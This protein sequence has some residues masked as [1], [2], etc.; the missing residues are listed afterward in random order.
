MR[1]QRQRIEAASIAP[2]TSAGAC[3]LFRR[4]KVWSRFCNRQG[5]LRTRHTEP[6]VF[7]SKRR[8]CSTCRRDGDNA[9]RSRNVTWR[10][11]A[12]IATSAPP[13]VSFLISATTSHC[14]GIQHD[15]RAHSFRHFHSNGIAFHADDERSADQF[16]PGGGAQADGSLRKNR[17][18]IA[19]ANIRRFCAAESSRS[20]VSEQAPLV[21]LSVRLESWPG[22]PAHLEQA[23]IRPARR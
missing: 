18:C 6:E 11:S 3:V 16:R 4:G 9:E 15:V 12:S 13:P 1:D 20:D 2:S 22:S 19:D 7:P 21:R 23:D 14:F 10:P 8:G 5:Q 17:N